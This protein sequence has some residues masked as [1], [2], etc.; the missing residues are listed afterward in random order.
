MNRSGSPLGRPAYFF[1]IKRT[2]LVPQG[3]LAWEQSSIP[4]A[5]F[6]KSLSGKQREGFVTCFGKSQTG[7]GEVT[8]STRSGEGSFGSEAQGGVCVRTGEAGWVRGL[9]CLLGGACWANCQWSGEEGERRRREE[10][11]WSREFWVVT[12]NEEVGLW[13]CCSLCK[14]KMAFPTLP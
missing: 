6:R 11:V 7:W 4:A 14:R 10:K 5:E 2:F 8:P 3:S 1:C 13:C 9:L 12:L